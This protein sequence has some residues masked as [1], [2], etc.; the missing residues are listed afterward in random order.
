MNETDIQQAIHALEKIL[1]GIK[2]VQEG[3][4]EFKQVVEWEEVK[5]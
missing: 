2:I 4:A 3:I 5:E 1:K